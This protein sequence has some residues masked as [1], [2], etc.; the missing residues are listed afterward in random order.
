M[1]NLNDKSRVDAKLGMAIEWGDWVR[2]G[3]DAGIKLSDASK[4][5]GKKFASGASVVKVS[6]V[7]VGK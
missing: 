1:T 7:I 4:K 2:I 6:D 5:F 3:F